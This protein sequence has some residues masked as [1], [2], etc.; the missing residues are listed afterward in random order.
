MSF[1]NI[2]EYMKFKVHEKAVTL[3]RNNL[4]YICVKWYLKHIHSSV[5]LNLSNSPLALVLTSRVN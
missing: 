4:L 3:S 5:K 1:M 2:K